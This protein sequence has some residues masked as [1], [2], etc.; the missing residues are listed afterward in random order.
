LIDDA[1][2]TSTPA[3]PEYR[4]IPCIPH[5]P[6]LFV[7]RRPVLEKEKIHKA[8]PIIFL[9]QQETQ[10]MFRQKKKLENR[11]LIN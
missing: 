10:T 5:Q 9:K 11:G 3:L 2:T 6:N 4:P 8:N 7:G 1:G